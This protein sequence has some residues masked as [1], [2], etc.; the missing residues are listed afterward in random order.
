MEVITAGED[1]MSRAI[2]SYFKSMKTQL[3]HRKDS[4]SKGENKQIRGP[5]LGSLA[6]F[7]ICSLINFHF[8]MFASSKISSKVGGLFFYPHVSGICSLAE[9][10]RH[11]TG[12][13]L[14]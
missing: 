4:R 13:Q 14:L 11:G 8:L 12:E 7:L 1:F 6:L 2:G 3:K 10:L 9:M 5:N